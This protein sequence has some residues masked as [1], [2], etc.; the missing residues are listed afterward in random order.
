MRNQNSRLPI[1]IQFQRFDRPTVLKEDFPRCFRAVL[2]Q[3]KHEP[4]RRVKKIAR[5]RRNSSVKIEAV[6]PA[7]QGGTRL[8]LAH[9]GFQCAD[10]RARNVRG[11]GDDQVATQ[12]RR[13]G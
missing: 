4:A 2:I 8:E 11:I 6:V 5:L 7:V 10:S 9:F 12:L 3:F 13:N 1:E